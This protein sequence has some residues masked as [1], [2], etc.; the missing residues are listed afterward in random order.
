MISGGA[1][2]IC[3]CSLMIWEAKL[4]IGTLCGSDQ[5]AAENL[6]PETRHLC[7]LLNAV[8]RFGNNI[9]P[10]RHNTASKNEFVKSIFSASLSL[11]SIMSCN[12]KDAALCFAI[13]NICVEISVAS[14]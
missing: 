2:G 14:T 7:I 9:I 6:P 8:S 1:A 13:D 11:N 10:Q 3:S 12:P 5:T 4:I